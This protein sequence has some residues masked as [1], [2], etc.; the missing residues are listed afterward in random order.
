M[1]AFDVIVAG[2]GSMGSA[3]CCHL[4]RRGVRVLGIEQFELP[5]EHGSHH[6]YSRMIRQSYHEHPDYVPLLQRAYQ[7]WDEL[8]ESGGGQQGAVFHRTGGLY[9]GPRDGVI[10][11]GALAAAREHGLKHQL[12]EASE[13]EQRFPD[14]RV[15]H[16]IVGFYEENAGVIRPEKALQAHCD[17][18]SLHGAEIRTGE[19]I[20]DWRENESSVTVRTTAGE[21]ETGH[22]V[23]TSGAWSGPMLRDLEVELSVTRQ[24]LA[25]FDAPCDRPG[26]SLAL[27]NF[28]CWF[29]ETEPPFGH[30][31]F[32]M[33]EFGQQ[34]FKIALHRP[35]EEVVDPGKQR[36]GASDEEIASLREVL[37]K[38]IPAADGPLLASC[39]CLYT[40]SGDG[41]FLLGQYPG[42]GHVTLA[43]GFSGHGYKFAPVMG[44]VLADLACEGTTP[45]QI[46]FLS[47]Q[48]F[49]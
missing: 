40:N 31:G 14:F 32:P 15:E 18:A 25:W 48:R 1:K 28:P 34:G 42:N 23:V 44:E 45:H 26:D 21:V 24:V 13:I 3:A 9:L 35:G 33:T 37:R 11:P 47:P 30:Y 29:I 7:L 39:T 38:W 19:K 10:V 46:E 5:H 2:V 43:A 22:L 49:A 12:L 8:N 20:L 17:L 27:G 41:H 36:V 4:A 6:G 16:D